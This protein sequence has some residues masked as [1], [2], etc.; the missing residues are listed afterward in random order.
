MFENIA[1]AFSGIWAHKMRSFLTMLGIIIG[2]ASIISIVSTIQGTNE[3]IKQNLIGSG[4]NTIV[5]SLYENDWPLELE[6]QS[7]PDTVMPLTETERERLLKIDSVADVSFYHVRNYT[8]NIFHGASVM[9]GAAI[10]GVD[11]HY[12]AT[13]G[14]QI[15]SG[16]AF[17]QIDYDRFDKVALIDTQTSASLF[18]SEDPIGQ[19]IDIGSEPYIVVGLIQKKSQFEP[20]IKSIEDYRM[21]AETSTG[22]VLIPD[23]DWPINYAYDEAHTVVIRT[24]TTDAMTE[25]GKDAADYLNEH[26]LLTESQIKYKSADRLEQAKQLQELSNSTN[27][28]LIWIASISLLVGGIGVMNIMLVSVTERTREIGLKKAL[29]AK[30]RLIL[31]QFLTEAA[32]LTSLGG[33]LG[34]AAGIGLSGVISKLTSTPSAISISAVLLAVLFSMLIGVIFGLLPAIK[35]SKLSPIEALRR[36]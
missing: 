4:T 3:Q 8:S 19:T 33:L 21:Y 15:I 20:V 14:Y 30:K 28:Q 22:M 29:G 17:N 31:G 10:Y 12:L 18:P 1:L 13:T 7:A 23:V 9:S 5:I 35:A 24:T 25:V 16:R 2:I 26:F 32:V 6:Y 11:Q 34:A 36:E 27:Q